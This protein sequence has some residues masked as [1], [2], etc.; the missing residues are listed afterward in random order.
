MADNE[1]EAVIY[2]NLRH[3]SGLCEDLFYRFR[4]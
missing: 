4:T 3:L 2:H 1:P